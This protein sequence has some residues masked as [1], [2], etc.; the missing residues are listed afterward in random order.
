MEGKIKAVATFQRGTYI[1]FCQLTPLS[2]SVP[3]Q[4]DQHQ[5]RLTRL[6]DTAPEINDVAHDDTDE[7]ND[8]GESLDLNGE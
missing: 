4:G 2:F 1:C 3:I 6:E 7:W 5:P 8:S